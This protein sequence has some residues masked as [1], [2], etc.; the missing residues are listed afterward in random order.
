VEFHR[1]VGF[2][3]FFLYDNGSEDDHEEALLPYRR[4]GL[5]VLHDWPVPFVGHRGR[6]GAIMLG[7]DHC[8]EEHGNDSHWI[9]FLD[10]DEFLFTSTGE[11]VSALLPRYERW[12]GVVVSRFDFGS[13]GHIA[14]PAGLVIE[15]YVHRI[16][17]PPDFE[18]YFKSIVM[19]AQTFRSLGPHQFMYRG[20]EAVNE[21]GRPV[22]SMNLTS[23]SLLR[24]NHYPTKSQEEF[25][26]KSTLWE[27]VGSPERKQVP[28]KGDVLDTTITGYVPALREA[29][30]RTQRLS[31]F[32]D[33]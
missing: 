18:A 23:Y 1:L 11:S 2:E 12:P 4:D 6:P 10:I 9:A 22:D 32:R 20:G 26:S 19:P 28:F 13:S 7:F 14:R 25:Q 16:E 5:V 30:E 29:L 17:Y 33:V 8:L 31:P 3:R 24:I 27:Q 15:N 21:N